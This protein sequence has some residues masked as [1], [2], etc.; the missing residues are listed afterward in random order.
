MFH[1]P[2]L[3]RLQTCVDL[4]VLAVWN[5]ARPHV[6]CRSSPRS[7]PSSKPLRAEEIARERGVERHPG[8]VQ[9]VARR[10]MD[11]GESAPLLVLLLSLVMVMVMVVVSALF[12]GVGDRFVG[13]CISSQLVEGI[14]AVRHSDHWVVDWISR[15]IAADTHST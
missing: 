7:E 4:L 6:G 9:G 15:E 11:R 12:A 14:R 5:P 3:S 10:T 8:R 13:R 1:S 2:V